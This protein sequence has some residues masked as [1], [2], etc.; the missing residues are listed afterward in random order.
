MQVARFSSSWCS[1]VGIGRAI[2]NL[3]GNC[4]AAVVIAFWERDI[5]SDR[6]RAALNGKT[7]EELNGVSGLEPASF[8]TF[9]V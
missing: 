5:N 7:V 9:G 4:V 1:Y 3:I 2:T 6:A 8:E